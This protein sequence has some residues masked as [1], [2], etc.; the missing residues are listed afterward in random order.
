MSSRAGSIALSWALVAT[1]PATGLADPA[2]W[3]A[4]GDGQPEAAGLPV[5]PNPV[6]HSPPDEDGTP[7]IW[8]GVAITSAVGSFILWGWGA[9][10]AYERDA[11]WD[12]WH[13]TPA[14]SPAEAATLT[15]FREARL[16]ALG[17]FVGGSVTAAL[18]ATAVG[19]AVHGWLVEDGEVEVAPGAGGL[20]VR[21]RF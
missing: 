18:A 4:P 6:A 3:A 17:Y 2:G 15:E 7:L 16:E 20:T 13:E 5:I 21:G 12:A 19:F 10:A 9:D 14:G 11:D 1:A 8:A